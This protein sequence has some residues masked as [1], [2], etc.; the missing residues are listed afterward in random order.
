VNTVLAAPSI[1]ALAAVIQRSSDESRASG[2]FH[3]DCVARPLR[4][5]DPAFL[6]YR[7]RFPCSASPRAETG[8]FVGK[9]LEFQ[10]MKKIIALLSVTSAGA[11][12]AAVD[13]G[14]VTAMADL[15]TDVG[16]IA[17]AAFVVTLLLV[18]YRKYSSAAK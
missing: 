12:S 17:L 14:V 6:H 2:H 5:I 8:F 10:I 15:K 4:W 7:I 16:T 3:D 13:A 1:A 9:T 11:A 18:A